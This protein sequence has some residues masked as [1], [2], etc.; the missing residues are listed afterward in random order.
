MTFSISCRSDNKIIW[1]TFSGTYHTQQLIKEIAPTVS[2]GA[3]LGKWQNIYR[4]SGI[5]MNK[6]SNNFEKCL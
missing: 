1:V 2:T 6:F 3:V 5:I 4:C